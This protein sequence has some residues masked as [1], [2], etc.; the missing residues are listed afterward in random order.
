MQGSLLALFWNTS[1]VNLVVATSRHFPCEIQ[2]QMISLLKKTVTR[3]GLS[4]A[5]LMHNTPIKSWAK[6]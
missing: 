5:H 3:F 6:F 1:P 4:T 2:S